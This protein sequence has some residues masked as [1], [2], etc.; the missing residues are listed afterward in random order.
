LAPLRLATG[1]PRVVSINH[2]IGSLRSAVSTKGFN[3][4]ATGS[5]QN[6]LQG[7]ISMS[8]NRVKNPTRTGVTYVI[9]LQRL[10]RRAIVRRCFGKAVLNGRLR[11]SP[12]IMRTENR[13]SFWK[14][15]KKHTISRFADSGENRVSDRRARREISCAGHTPFSFAVS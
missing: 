3:R 12:E 4:E 10:N 1:R 13:A 9:Y 5:A 11:N 15:L 2:D 7:E 6:L 8:Q 14:S